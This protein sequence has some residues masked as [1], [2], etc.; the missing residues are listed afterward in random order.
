MKEKVKEKA[1][2]ITREKYMNSNN[3]SDS[4][5]SLI[6]DIKEKRET[7]LIN[8][9]KRSPADKFRASNISIC[10]LEICHS[11]LSWNDKSLHNSSLQSRFDRGDLEERTVITELL[12]LGFSIIESQQPFEIKNRSG[13]TICRGHVDG[14][15]SYLDRI[16]PIEI[17]S[18]HPNIFA[19]INSLTDFLKNPLHRKYL[20]QLQLYLYG[21]N[22]SEGIF[23]LSNCLG[24]YKFIPVILDLEE[25]EKIISRL[26]RLWD[27]NIK[28][29]IL[30]KSMDFDEK[31][32]NFCN[33]KH[34]CPC[35]TKYDGMVMV[36]DK[37]LETSLARRLELKPLVD[38]YNNL[39][40]NIK[41]QFNKI[42]EVVVGTDWIIRT[43]EFERKNY[44]VPTEIK[45]QYLEVKSYKKVDIIKL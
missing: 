26:E 42:G 25:V 37:E 31:T 39:D 40:D 36:D 41:S 11:I 14:K 38:E 4:L 30:P 23:I 18:M 24:A 17:K 27:E 29:N 12:S 45:S 16:F 7:S 32:C 28:T 35:L 34:L 3:Y 9:I 44:N 8:K 5:I 10:D 2:E 21:N 15:I 13:E 33:F 43:K 1:E 6:A 19:S 22:Q 20:L